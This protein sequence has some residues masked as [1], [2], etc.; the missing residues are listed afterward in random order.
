M[1]DDKPTIYHVSSTNQ[2]GGITA[3]TVIVGPKPRIV[4]AQVSARLSAIPR[5]RQVKVMMSFLAG[6][7]GQQFA[8]QILDWMRGNG[9]PH[10][11]GIDSIQ[12][13]GLAEPLLIADQG[14]SG[15]EIIVGPIPT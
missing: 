8:K 10:T 14:S 4:D 12:H 11:Q 6:S 15:I 3:G 1:A 7:E 5:T 9:Y 2:S 13:S